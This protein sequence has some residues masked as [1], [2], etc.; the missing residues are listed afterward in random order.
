MSITQIIS[1]NFFTLLMCITALAI[2]P[3]CFVSTKTKTTKIISS[4]GKI[5][6]LT[7]PG[8]NLKLPFPFHRV[9][10][11]VDISTQMI[12]DH[13]TIKTKDNIFS[14]LNV[15][16]QMHISNPKLYF[17]KYTDINTQVRTYLQN[18]LQ[19]EYA[20]IKFLDTFDSKAKMQSHIKTRIE[21]EMESFGYTVENV[22]LDNL[23]PSATVKELLESKLTIRATPTT[24]KKTATKSKST[25][26]RKTTS[27]T[28]K[29][30]T[31][32]TSDSNLI[33]TLIGTSPAEILGTE[34]V[35][36]SKA[37]AKRA[38]SKEE[39]ESLFR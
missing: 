2:L 19:E 4:F 17:Y 15:H 22:F 5:S 38:T 31:G 34:Q 6:K 3:T 1:E 7:T 12:D 28:A 20:K 33:T 39:V 26:A 18:V 9:T 11:T 37:K 24:V 8:I 23:A 14:Q 16:L 35:S 30:T 32:K 10:S 29:K 13:I 25:T 21:T 27:K 36:K